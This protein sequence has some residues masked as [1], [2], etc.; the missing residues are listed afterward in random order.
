MS[1]GYAAVHAKLDAIIEL[2]SGQVGE[3][4]WYTRSD[5][6]RLM[7]VGDS[8]IKAWVASGKLHEFKLGA[9]FRY[10]RHDVHVLMAAIETASEPRPNSE[11]D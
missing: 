2:L 3:V 1:A 11:T 7:D 5:I 6:C 10:R 8:T 4:G 9:S